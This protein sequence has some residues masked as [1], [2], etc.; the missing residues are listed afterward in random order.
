[1]LLDKTVRELLAAVSSPDPTPGGGSAAALSGALGASLL[2]MVASL[3]RT[4]TGS[5]DEKAALATVAGA[6]TGIR[7][8]LADAVDADTVAYD[9]VIAAYKLPKASADDQHART[10]AIGRALRVAT[11]VPLDVIRL[12]AAALAE[13][14]PVARHGHRGAASDVGVAIALLRAAVHGARLNVEANLAGIR[15]EAYVAG[16]RGRLARHL[17]IAETA[18]NTSA[19]VLANG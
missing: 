12:S 5:D 4:R 8:E 19:T 14:E 10:A 6:L 17:A 7:R 13:G 16:I 1:M 15:D 9:G 3:S 2:I 11:E 18:A